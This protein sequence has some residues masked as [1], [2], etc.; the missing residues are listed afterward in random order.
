[1]NTEEIIS[2]ILDSWNKP[3]VFVDNEHIIRYMNE[4]AL[5]HYAK[6][7]NIIGKDIFHCHNSKSRDIILKLYEQMKQG[8]N[9]VLITDNEKHKVY[10]RAVKDKSGNLLGYCERYEPPD[11]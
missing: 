4:P 9:E 6:W 7:G 1:M 3:I 10:M 11:R 2:S 5:K 8:E